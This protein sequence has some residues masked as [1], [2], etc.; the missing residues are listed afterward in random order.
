MTFDETALGPFERHIGYC[1]YHSLWNDQLHIVPANLETASTLV[2]SCCAE[3]NTTAFK[4]FYAQSAAGCRKEN[5]FTSLERSCREIRWR[6]NGALLVK[7]IYVTQDH[8]LKCRFLVLSYRMPLFSE[9]FC[10]YLMEES[11]TR[12]FLI[13]REHLLLEISR[14]L[15]LPNLKGLSYPREIFFVK[16]CNFVLIHILVGRFVNILIFLHT[17]MHMMA[18]HLSK[19]PKKTLAGQ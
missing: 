15:I 17:C 19:W 5:L 12:I 4:A 14:F 10:C 8:E 9:F 7:S 1:K 3:E 18:E 6:R 16:K 11:K 13:V 2:R